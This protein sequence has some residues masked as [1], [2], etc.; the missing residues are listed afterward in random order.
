MSSKT[1]GISKGVRVIMTLPADTQD[2]A[3]NISKTSTATIRK[4]SLGVSKYSVVKGANRIGV[5]ATT[6][7]S[8]AVIR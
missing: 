2:S 6:R 8:I 4:I 3:L 5:T 1:K 7:S